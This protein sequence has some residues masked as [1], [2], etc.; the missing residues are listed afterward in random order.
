MLVYPGAIPLET[1]LL[2]TNKFAMLALGF[3]AQATIG[4]GTVVDG[5][6][7]LATSPTPDM[8]V[9]VAPGSMFSYQPVDSAAYSSLGSDSA[10]SV[11]KA[12]I[13][14]TATTFLLTAPSTSG[15]SQNYLIEAA[16][17]ETDGGSIVLPYYNAASP[18]SPYLGPGNSGAAQNTIRQQRVAL[19]LKAGA[20]APAGTQVTPAVDS[21]YVALYVITVNNGQT[22]ITQA[23]CNSA[24]VPGAPFITTKLPQLRMRLSAGLNLYVGGSG[25]S[26]S[27]NGLSAS[28]AFA[29][30]QAAWDALA[31]GYDLNGQTVTINLAAG[32]YNQSATLGGSL[33][34]QS[35]SPV[36]ITGPSGVTW[37]NAGAAPT[38]FVT[39]G[40]FVQIQGGMT[41][42]QTNGTAVGA[43]VV[44]AGGRALLGNLNWSNSNSQ[45]I[46][47]G[48]GGQANVVAS[49]TISF[50]PAIHVGTTAG[51]TFSCDGSE[52]GGF[53]ITLTGTP[54]F[55]TAYA[56]ANACGLQYY[57]ST[58]F[59]GSA[60]GARFSVS[61]GGGIDTT[62]AGAN[63]LPGNSAGSTTSPGW[64]I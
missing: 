14:L 15:Y 21:G 22:S 12:G 7:L 33:T 9:T 4:T 55:A 40:A 24:F 41:I 10:D 16:F 28:T 62:N 31:N 5:L 17:S 25:S 37:N 45:H 39:N 46:F 32:S 38:I 8:H 6:G 30:V 47:V 44:S 54:G 13:N 43:L 18:S 56:Y 26:D 58:A 51:G 59:S 29:T 49:Y 27:N 23:Q 11:V 53:T 61:S 63:Y 35:S 48:A 64:Y 34:G 2:N 60:T 52:S 20:A 57:A 19:Q 1:D 36:I 42:Q 50:G 3:L